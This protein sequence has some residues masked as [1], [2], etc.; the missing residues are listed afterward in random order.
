M[1][2]LILVIGGVAIFCFYQGYIPIGVI[3]LGGFSKKYGWP[4]LVITMGF[5]L[6]KG[7]WFVGILP[8]LL[9]GWNIIGLRL[10]YKDRLE[11]TT[12]ENGTG[13]IRINFLNYCKGYFS[14]RCDLSKEQAEILVLD[15][16]LGSHIDKAKQQWLR[17]DLDVGTD[18]DAFLVPKLFDAPQMERINNILDKYANEYSEREQEIKD[19]LKSSGHPCGNW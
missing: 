18:P 1:V 13:D 9:I 12:R 5:L 11:E 8:L 17:K 6:V 16:E 2:L 4:A 14:E 15:P 19:Y 7:H 10:F 3:C